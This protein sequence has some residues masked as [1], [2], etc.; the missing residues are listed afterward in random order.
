[1]KVWLQV[2][3]S[4]Y[5]QLFFFIKRSWYKKPRKRVLAFYLKKTK[6]SPRVELPGEGLPNA[7][8]CRGAGEAAACGKPARSCLR[9][10]C[11]RLPIRQA[12]HSLPS[13]SQHTQAPELVL[14]AS[15]GQGTV[16]YSTRNT[17][18]VNLL[19]PRQGDRQRSSNSSAERMS[20][21]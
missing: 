18:Q 20:A 5:L 9:R 6:T 19:A 12:A 13:L 7:W 8:T 15:D 1:M 16:A 2:Q 21:G 11:G 17:G 10:G 4:H 14:L 3:L